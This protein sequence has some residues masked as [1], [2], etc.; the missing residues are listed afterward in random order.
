MKNSDY[1]KLC[2]A[3]AAS[4]TLALILIPPFANAVEAGMHI[5]LVVTSS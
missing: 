2:A 4:W 3:V 5:F 1:L